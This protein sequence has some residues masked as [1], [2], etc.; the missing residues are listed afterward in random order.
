M[1]YFNPKKIIVGYDFKFGQNQSGCTMTLKDWG[2]K[3][4]IEIEEITPFSI[5]NLGELKAPKLEH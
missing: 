4:N 2:N 3:N 1:K 5:D